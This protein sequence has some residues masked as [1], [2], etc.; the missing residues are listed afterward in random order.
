MYFNLPMACVEDVVALCPTGGRGDSQGSTPGISYRHCHPTTYSHPIRR[1]QRKYFVLWKSNT[2]NIHLVFLK[3]NMSFPLS[4]NVCSSH[5]LAHVLQSVFFNTFRSDCSTS[6]TSRK[7]IQACLPC[8]NMTLW[9]FGHNVHCQR[10]SPP[11]STLPTSGSKK[12]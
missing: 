11:L 5:G 9:C 10:F 8:G 6:S 7:Q 4:Q 12:E 1:P 3:G 2:E